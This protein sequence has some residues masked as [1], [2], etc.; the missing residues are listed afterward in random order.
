MFP[1]IDLYLT[2][3]KIGLFSFGG[4]YAALPLMQKML[5]GK[6]LNMAEFS[7]IVT[8]SQITPGPIAINAATFVGVRE[9]GIWGGIV[10]TLG[11]ITP[12]VIIAL[13]L[14]YIYKRYRTQSTLSN[15]LSGIKPVAVGMI[16]VSA[17][18]LVI[19]SATDVISIIVLLGA[20]L[21]L[22]F[23]KLK[24]VTVI[25]ITGFLG[26]GIEFIKSIW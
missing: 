4:G 6:Y 8:I 13:S 5:L 22:R 20:V 21:A 11:I 19:D 16:A 10:A 18:T 25:L 17:V 24:P 1:M 7:D 9:M 12:S 26:A 23:R 14:G 3:A 15:I 2:F